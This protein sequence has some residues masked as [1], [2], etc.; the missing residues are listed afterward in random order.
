MLGDTPLL[1]NEQIGIEWRIHANVGIV[2][3]KN[4][5]AVAVDSHAFRHPGFAVGLV[6]F[7]ANIGR[8]LPRRVVIDQTAEEQITG[9]D[10]E[11]LRCKIAPSRT[12][13]KSTR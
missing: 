5:L 10:P 6:L 1:R 13:R 9:V 8:E 11:L 3:L 2:F 4:L 7:E 12:D